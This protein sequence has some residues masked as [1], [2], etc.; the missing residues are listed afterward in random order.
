MSFNRC[1][2]QRRCASGVMAYN[3][4]HIIYYMRSTAQSS[5]AVHRTRRA[6]RGSAPSVTPAAG[7]S[8]SP[9][10]FVTVPNIIQFGFESAV[11]LSCQVSQTPAASV[12]LK[13][14]PLPS[15][16]QSSPTG[17]PL[18]NTTLSPFTPKSV[19]LDDDRFCASR[20]LGYGVEY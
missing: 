13:Q 1:L 15:P 9:Y 19:V 7:K 10:S 12:C 20:S 18:S 2:Y 5:C 11:L 3:A 16:V 4:K 8:E 6:G 14:C 17:P